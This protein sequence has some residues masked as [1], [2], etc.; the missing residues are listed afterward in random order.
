MLVRDWI[1]GDK[2]TAVLTRELAKRLGP[3]HRW[4]EAWEGQRVLISGDLHYDATG[5]VRKV[6][7]QEVEPISPD[8]VLLSDLE[9]IDLLG[10]RSVSEHLAHY[11]GEDG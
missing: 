1:T 8:P 2:F 6:D 5:R 10:G 9:G 7:A 3:E 4:N 11:W